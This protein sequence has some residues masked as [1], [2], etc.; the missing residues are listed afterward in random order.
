MASTGKRFIFRHIVG[1]LEEAGI[2]LLL[3]T[4]SAR[5][6]STYQHPLAQPVSIYTWLYSQLPNRFEIKDGR[7]VGIHEIREDHLLHGKIPVLVD[8][9]LLSDE[10]FDVGSGVMAQVD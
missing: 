7:K 5:I 4:P 9:H 10:E 1:A 3:L 2:E 6:S 8:A